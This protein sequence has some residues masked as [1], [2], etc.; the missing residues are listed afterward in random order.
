MNNKTNIKVGSN[1]TVKN[2]LHS[3]HSKHWKNNI[4]YSY[5]GPIEECTILDEVIT[6]CKH[7][8]YKSYTFHQVISFL[9]KFNLYPTFIYIIKY[10]DNYCTKISWVIT[11][12]DDN[13]VW[14]R[15]FNNSEKGGINDIINENNIRYKE[16]DVYMMMSNYYEPRQPIEIP[17]T[18]SELLFND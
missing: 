9:N 4:T 2:P 3:Y 7:T 17:A 8:K 10:D 15:K 16:F 5:S 13:Y 1:I 11:F 14:V 18:L 6:M 12:N